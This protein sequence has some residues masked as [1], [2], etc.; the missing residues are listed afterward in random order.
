MISNERRTHQRSRALNESV[1]SIRAKKK[2]EKGLWIVFI[3]G[4]HS[5]FCNREHRISTH[6]KD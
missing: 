1:L 5:H 6:T 2:K 4:K 3:I